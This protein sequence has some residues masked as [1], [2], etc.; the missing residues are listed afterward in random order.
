MEQSWRLH[1]AVGSIIL[2]VQVKYKYEKTWGAGISSLTLFQIALS[3]SLDTD[4]R[5]L[6]CWLFNFSINS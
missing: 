6:V 5:F 4:F 1:D 2:Q 3:F